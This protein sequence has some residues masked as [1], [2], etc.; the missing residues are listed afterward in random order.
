MELRKNPKEMVDI[1]IY[2]YIYTI[3]RNEYIFYGFTR[4]FVTKVRI[5]EL[6]HTSIEISKTK[7]GKG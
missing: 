5:S 3:E 4:L 6:E 2:I 7:K 1:Y